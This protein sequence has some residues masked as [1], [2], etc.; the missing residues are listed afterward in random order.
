MNK[1]KNDFYNKKEK[2]TVYVL[3]SPIEKIFY[4]NQCLT[5]SLKETYRH[6]IKGRRQTTKEFINHISPNRPC[7][8]VLENTNLTKVEAYN[9]V[10]IWIKIFLE[11]GYLSFNNKKLIELSDHL[12]FENRRIYDQR[13]TVNLESFLSCEN[14]LIPIYNKIICKNY[15]QNNDEMEN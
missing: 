10:L 2:R 3:I 8:F 11:N 1:S 6:N 14:C 7:V 5:T 13:K 4:I 12:Y 15:P 9:Y